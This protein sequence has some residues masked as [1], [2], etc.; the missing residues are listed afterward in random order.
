MDLYARLLEPGRVGIATM[1]VMKERDTAGVQI[2]SR[3]T[4]K[5]R[6][7]EILT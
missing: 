5:A 7:G 1:E 2:R 3:D 6:F 4:L